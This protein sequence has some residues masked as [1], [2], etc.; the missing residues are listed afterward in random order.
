[1]EAQRIK[2]LTESPPECMSDPWPRSVGFCGIGQAAAAAIL[3]AWELPYAAG[4]ALKR[5]EEKKKKSKGN[6][7]LHI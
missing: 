7:H 3:L 1:M 6:M 5:K 2:N 4:A